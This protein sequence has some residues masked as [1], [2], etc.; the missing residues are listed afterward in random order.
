M[1]VLGI[2]LQRLTG[3]SAK[4]AV[5][6]FVML[7]L[8]MMLVPLPPIA[9][10]LL[11]TL[12]IGIS[13]LVL[14]AAINIRTF[15]DFIAF[16]TILLLT[17]LLRLSLNV[18]STRVVLIDGH[19]GPDA[20]GKVIEAFGQ[21]MIGSNIAVG[22]VIFIVI[23]IIN[24]IVITKGSGR[25]AEVSA[26]FALDSMPGKQMAID[27]DLN[28]GIMYSVEEEHGSFYVGLS[29]YHING[30]MRNFS[31]LPEE[32]VSARFTAHAGKTI[33]LSELNTLILS[34]M[35]VQQARSESFLGGLAYGHDFGNESTELSLYAGL[36]Y[37]SKDAIIPYIGYVYNNF[38]LGLTYDATISELNL[39]G[40]RN[41]SFELSMTYWFPDR[42]AY[43]R[44]VPWY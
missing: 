12:S 17:T 11:F 23:T 27:A 13:I 4:A 37:R 16:P 19:N 28:A 9:L 35:Y 6:I 34:G 25:V 2:T 36:W 15:K 39:S 30:P 42:S 22:I 5:P 10:D 24:F 18:A 33:Y 8:V 29:A 38:Q 21:F 44:F 20:A 26:R 1:A 43:K 40:T 7:V 14:I 41:K 3:S 32:K 31:G